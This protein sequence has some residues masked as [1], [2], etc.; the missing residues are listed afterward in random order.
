[1]YDCN[2]SYGES[3]Y[4]LLTRNGNFIYL[5]SKGYLEIDKE[6][7][8]VHSFV[9]V[10]TL[11]DEEEG[12]RCVQEMKHKFSIIIDAQIPSST[13]DIPASAKPQQL[14]KAVLC[15]IQNLQKSASSDG[16][17]LDT[18][19]ATSSS[20]YSNLRKS[21]ISFDNEAHI[22]HASLPV[23]S[24]SSCSIR[25]TKTPPMSLVPPETA[26]VRTSISKGVSM[27]NIAAGRH[28]RGHLQ[29]VTKHPKSPGGHEELA[30]E[31]ANNYDAA[32]DTDISDNVSRQSYTCN[33][34]HKNDGTECENCDKQLRERRISNSN[35][36][37]STSWSDN[38]EDLKPPKRRLKSTGNISKYF[39]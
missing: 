33:C 14:E 7:N 35:S 21:T 32:S 23:R 16:E 17:E 18:E 10:N 15:L 12:K 25:S 11:L 30:E 24:V 27:V 19:A 8:K 4:R 13:V 5:R 34:P 1:M 6:T 36:K 3:T 28:L 20:V 37:R 39:Q 22:S 31:S 9:C 2:S 38:D 29:Q 26:S